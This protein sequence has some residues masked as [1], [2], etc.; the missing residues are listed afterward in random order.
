M[1][2]RTL[3]LDIVTPDRL[4]FEGEVAMVVAPAAGG[5]VGILPLHAAFLSELTV[6]ELRFKQEK[7]GKEV[8]EYVAVSG[9]FIEVFE[10]RV[11][12]VTPAAEFAR[13]IDIERA[14]A[15]RDAAE[16]EL[17]KLDGAEFRQAQ[18]RLVRAESRLRI[19][20]QIPAK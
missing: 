12:I 7:D 13:E 19:A 8:Q 20:N 5:E 14:K 3:L 4:L 2:D 11:T 1:P 17:K 10:D 9:G 15:A 18:A 16:A 6:G